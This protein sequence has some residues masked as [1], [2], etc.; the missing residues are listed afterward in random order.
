MPSQIFKKEGYEISDLDTGGSTQYYGFLDQIGNW[1]IIQM[2][3]TTVRYVRGSSADYYPDI[4]N[5]RANLDYDYFN[6]VFGIA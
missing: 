4:W 5:N 2:T 6:N 3:T 1:Y